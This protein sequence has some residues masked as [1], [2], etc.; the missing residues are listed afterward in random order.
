MAVDAVERIRAEEPDD[1]LEEVDEEEP[2][3]QEDLGE[4]LLVEVDAGVLKILA[5]LWGETSNGWCCK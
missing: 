4:R 3:D 5:G 2:A 1:L